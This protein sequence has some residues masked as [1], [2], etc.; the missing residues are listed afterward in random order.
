MK[1]ERTTSSDFERFKEHA[2]QAFR[3]WGVDD[4]DIRFKHQRLS[5]AMANCSTDLTG[6]M[7]RLRLSTDFGPNPITD[8]IL[9]DTARHE[10]VHVLLAQV[11]NIGN[12]RWATEDE[13]KAAE[14]ALVQRLLRVLP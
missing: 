9:R 3:A 1:S 5:G 2:I 4:W 10:A 14:E 6:R 12:S 13:F 8:A 11:T 7:A